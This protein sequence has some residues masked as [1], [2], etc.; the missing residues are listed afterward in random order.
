MKTLY[1]SDLD[2]TLLRNDETLSAH[3]CET[4]NALVER[5][6][7]FSYATARSY[8]TASKV[9]RGLTARIP[10]IVYNG[11]F[12]I[13][14]ATGDILLT[15]FFEQDVSP[16]LDDLIA[17]GVYPIV[18]AVVEGKETFTYVDSL[19]SPAMRQYV[20]SRGSDPRKRPAEDVRRLYEGNIFYFTCIGDPEKLAPL[21]EKYRGEHHC[22]YQ[23]DMYTQA[24]WLEIMPAAASK[25][26][27][28]RQLK[29][30]LQCDRLVVF[31]D[32]KND[33]DMFHLAD[34]SCAM[35]NAVDELKAAA[36]HIIGSNEE[37]GVARWLVEH[38]EFAE[39]RD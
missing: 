10:L 27:A 24:Q 17:H 19:C 35:D 22:V 2:G 11:A 25:A 1:V 9:T 14:N 13:D 28:I 34:E 39:K 29:A 26:N 16:L 3:T 20:D 8:V 31:G 7:L 5:G 37:D 36:T 6:M 32:G 38:A 30:H 4:I 21:Y 23:M 12:T 18:Y 15:N 33:L